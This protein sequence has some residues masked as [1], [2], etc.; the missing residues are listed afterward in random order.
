MQSKKMY[1]RKY[2]LKKTESILIDRIKISTSRDIDR[3]CRNL[4]YDDLH[5]YES[6]FIILLS[7]AHVV[8]ECKIIGY[9][10][11]STG[12]MTSTVVDIRLLA[13]VAIESLCTKIVLV[14][15]HP[16]GNNTPS[17]NDRVLTQRCKETMKLFDIAILDHIIL[18]ENSYYSFADEGI[19]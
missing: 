5:L 7:Q 9:S 11:I 16:S 2:E 15:N 13:K 14:H 6:F 19:L 10:P 1:F 12:G 8:Q 4:Y 17:E 18:C 3:L